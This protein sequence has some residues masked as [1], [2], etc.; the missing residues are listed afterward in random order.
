[1]K[2]VY[3]AQNPMDAH[4]MRGF[5]Q[6]EGIDSIV[7]GEDLFAIQGGVP[8]IYP[9]VWVIDDADCERARQL[10]SV[11]EHG[12]GDGAAEAETWQCAKCGETLADQFTECW[13]CGASRYPEEEGTQG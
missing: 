12:L 2:K 13:Q 4:M 8:V 10:V 6:A 3:V 1:M 7:Q 11:S 5:L 9:T